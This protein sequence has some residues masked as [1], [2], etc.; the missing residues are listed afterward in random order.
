MLA[1]FTIMRILFMGYRRYC[2][3]SQA[4]PFLKCSLPM[5]LLKKICKKKC[6]A[7]WAN[8]AEQIL[9]NVTL[10][11]DNRRGRLSYVTPQ[12]GYKRRPGCSSRH[13]P[14]TARNKHPAKA[15]TVCVSH[16]IW[17]DTT[18]LCDEL[19]VSLHVPDHFKTFHKPQN[20]KQKVWTTH[21]LTIQFYPKDFNNSPLCRIQFPTLCCLAFTCKTKWVSLALEV[22]I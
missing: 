9:E 4:S 1:C 7:I 14:A 18:L 11:N 6:T 20:E 21:H 5:K 8:L 15:Y 10:Q 16:G 17:S 2:F 13:I 19:Y 22:A 12:L 3:A